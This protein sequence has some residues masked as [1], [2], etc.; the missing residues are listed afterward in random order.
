MSFDDV[1]ELC[2]QGVACACSGVVVACGG[3]RVG[4]VGK[5][6]KCEREENFLHIIQSLRKYTFFCLKMGA[7]A[8]P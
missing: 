5:A 7:F 4:K 8:K 1:V 2:F 6:G 3:L